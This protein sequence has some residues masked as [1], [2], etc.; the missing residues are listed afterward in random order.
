MKANRTTSENANRFILII[1][2]ILT[3]ACTGCSE[4]PIGNPV[5]EEASDLQGSIV[6]EYFKV[7][8][9]GTTVHAFGGDV[10]LEFSKG[11][12]PTSTRF[13][14]VSFPLEHLDLHG[15]NVMLRAF[16]LKNVTNKN[17]FEK[18]VKIIMRYDLC[19]Y[20]VC[21]PGEESDLAIFKFIGDMHAFHEIQAL[22]EC[23]MDCSCKTV[24][25]CLDECGIY[26]VG[27]K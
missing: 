5:E 6:T 25:G 8:P 9:A 17:E 4:N 19:D 3:F 26:I 1:A 16:A 10:M 13:S 20:N 15:E 12:I 23:I 22:G 24:M 27:E 21:Q 7:S 11:T 18:P 14:I 2:V